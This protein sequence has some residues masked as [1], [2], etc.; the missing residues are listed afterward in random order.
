MVVVDAFEC[1]YPEW[2]ELLEACEE[3]AILCGW[4]FVLAD[5]MNLGHPADSAQLRAAKERALPVA[6]SYGDR[7]RA[8]AA[9]LGRMRSTN[10]APA[11]CVLHSKLPCT[12]THT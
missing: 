6:L 5:F 7:A 9:E 11:K 10:L 1:A 3:Y 4:R 12:H 2:S 8:C